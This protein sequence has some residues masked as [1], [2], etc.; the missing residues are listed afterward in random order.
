M[1]ANRIIDRNEAARILGLSPNRVSCLISKGRLAFVEVEEKGWAK[2]RRVDGK[3]RRL[4]VAD[5]EA[6]DRRYPVR[7]GGTR[8]IKGRKVAEAKPRYVPRDKLAAAGFIVQAEA[9][10]ISGMSQANIT[11]LAAKGV[12]P[13]VVTE[14]G[15]RR[16]PRA[17]FLTFVAEGCPRPTMSDRK[18]RGPGLTIREVAEKLL[19]S[20]N[21]VNWWIKTGR[22][23]ATRHGAGLSIEPAD[24]DVFLAGPGVKYRR[25]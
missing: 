6:F 12:V 17:S 15:I 4:R 20:S 9:A 24:L 5:V 8:S 19:V 11:R 2:G 7:P 22:L 13:S 18:R 14:D 3:F 21:A 1:E 23:K 16:L 10:R 25:A